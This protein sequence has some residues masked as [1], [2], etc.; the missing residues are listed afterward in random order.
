MQYE[1]HLIV[2]I[3]LLGATA[4]VEDRN[5]EASLRIYERLW[6]EQTKPNNIDIKSFMLSDTLVFY[7]N[8]KSYELLNAFYAIHSLVCRI[9]EQLLRDSLLSR[10][11]ITEGAFYIDVEKNIYFGSAF[12]DAYKLE[13]EANYPR[14]IIEPKLYEELE[15]LAKTRNSNLPESPDMWSA[16]ALRTVLDF[17]PKDKDGYQYVKYNLPFNKKELELEITQQANCK[18]KK[19]WLWLRR[20]V[21]L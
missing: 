13:K 8:L 7:I 2:Y 3:D 10:G 17:T 19:K 12:I 20:L 9:Q 1:D 11:A 5:F 18:N 6:K 4:L 15:E 14:V 21:S 16:M